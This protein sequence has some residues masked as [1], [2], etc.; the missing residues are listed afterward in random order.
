MIITLIQLNMPQTTHKQLFQ[1]TNDL[2][3][4]I[5]L[6]ICPYL[7]PFPPYMHYLIYTSKQGTD[8]NKLRYSPNAFSTN[9][10]YIQLDFFPT[11]TIMGKL[12]KAFKSSCK[13]YRKPG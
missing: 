13:L 3:G 1:I 8:N 6:H 9:N 7:A 10:I 2:L 12:L 5:T 11:V 4:R